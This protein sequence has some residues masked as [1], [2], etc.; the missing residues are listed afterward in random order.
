M[1]HVHKNQRRAICLSVRNGQTVLC[2][3]ENS[4][5]LAM[6]NLEEMT[7]GE[8]LEAMKVMD[9]GAGNEKI[10]FK[11]TQQVSFPS[12]KAKFQGRL[13]TAQK[14]R[15][16]L[17]KILG[18]LGFGKGGPRRF[19]VVS[20][21]PEG[22]PDDISFETFEHPSYATLK[23]TNDIIKSIMEHHGVD[24]HL[25]P[26]EMEEPPTPEKRKQKEKIM[27]EVLDDPNDNSIVVEKRES[28]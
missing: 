6:E 23:T 21:E 18:I 26:Y 11:T 27:N 7:V 8:L 5:N 25:H 13:W 17:T 16:E 3:E 1:E 2:G 9:A 10:T 14:A 12:F 28:G 19:K 4:V 24:A 22:W 15:S 20:D